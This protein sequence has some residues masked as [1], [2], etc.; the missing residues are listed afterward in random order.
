[1]GTG[2]SVGPRWYQP[3]TFYQ[4][5]QSCTAEQQSCR[6][7]ELHSRGAELQTQTLGG[8]ARDDTTDTLEGKIAAKKKKKRWMT[9]ANH[10]QGGKVV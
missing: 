7:A 6:A 2:A 10:F 1:M 5:E 4:A 3:T 9:M 8:D